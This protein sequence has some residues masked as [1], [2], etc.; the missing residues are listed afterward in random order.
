MAI[1]GHSYYYHTQRD[2]VENLQS[3][4]SQHFADAT[5]AVL[6]HLLQ[7]GSPLNTDT[8]W[9]PPNMVYYSFYDR[10]FIYYSMNAA[11]L[12]CACIVLVYVGILA[13]RVRDSERKVYRKALAAAFGNL[14]IGIIAAVSV[15]VFFAYG[16]K[17]SHTWYVHLV[18]YGCLTSLPM[19]RFRD[20]GLLTNIYR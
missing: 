19:F 9:S 4:S 15:A 12:L 18:S 2:T 3:G 5:I 7:V 20:P 17:K 6:D 1:V 11:N 14:L 10:I 8:P 16:L 13:T